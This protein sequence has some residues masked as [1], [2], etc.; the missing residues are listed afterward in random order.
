VNVL[1]LGD[2]DPLAIEGRTI[3]DPWGRDEQLLEQVYSRIDR[4]VEQLA[5]L[6]AR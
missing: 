3:P 1:V 2:L 4:C 6:I 5:D